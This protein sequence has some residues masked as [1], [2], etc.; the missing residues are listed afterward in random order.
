MRAADA[1]AWKVACC[2]SHLLST[3]MISSSAQAA[4]RVNGSALLEGE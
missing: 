2:L 1:L 4:E 3:C